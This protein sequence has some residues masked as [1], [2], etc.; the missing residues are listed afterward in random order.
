M[1]L[2][3]RYNTKS[4]CFDARVF[5]IVKICRRRQTDKK[6]P[7]TLGSALLFVSSSP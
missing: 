2:F 6:E 1:A 4:K 5:G 7:N 3:I